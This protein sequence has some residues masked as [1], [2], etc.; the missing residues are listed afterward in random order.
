MPQPSSQPANRINSDNYNQQFNNYDPNAQFEGKEDRNVDELLKIY[1]D[2]AL[3]RGGN[4][5]FHIGKH[6]NLYDRNKSKT[7][8]LEEFKRCCREYSV[9][10]S[11]SECETLFN[12]FDYDG[13]GTIDYNEFLRILRGPMNEK[14]KNAVIRL[15]ERLDV[16]GDGYIDV[17]DIKLMYNATE[18]PDV[19]NRKKTADQVYYDFIESINTYTQVMK[20]GANKDKIS[21]DEWLEY[22]NNLSV[23]IDKDNYFLHMLDNCW[24]RKK[25]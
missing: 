3:K 21:L 18:H 14:R 1:R 19:I 20:G 25:I 7:L 8:D 2:R 6:F 24:N 9:G 22:Y 15:F 4:T 10:L 12:A 17:H 5:I 23:S 11:P 16:K 13:V